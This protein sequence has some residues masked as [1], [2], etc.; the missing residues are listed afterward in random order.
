[1]GGCAGV[2]RVINLRVDLLDKAIEIIV[3]EQCADRGVLNLPETIVW[4]N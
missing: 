4:N 3:G 1:M 2:I